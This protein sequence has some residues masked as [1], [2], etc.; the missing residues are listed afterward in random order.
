VKTN[1]ICQGKL[2]AVERSASV[3]LVEGDRAMLL[4]RGWTLI[5]GQRWVPCSQAPERVKATK[6]LRRVSIM[7]L[8]ITDAMLSVRP[9]NYL[10]VI[11]IS[12]I[13]SGTTVAITMPARMGLN[14]VTV[15]NLRATM[16]LTNLRQQAVSVEETALDIITKVVIMAI[17]GSGTAHIRICTAITAT[18]DITKLRMEELEI[19]RNHLAEHRRQ[20][21][22]A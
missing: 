18:A 8:H 13:N 1:A 9:L 14:M 4:D 16:S 6:I 10:H 7:R 5:L 20:L 17:L 11:N 12:N 15:T 22:L 19:H 21:I 3:V 2:G